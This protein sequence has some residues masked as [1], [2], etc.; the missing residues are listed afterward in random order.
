M[1][2]YFSI[3]FL[4]VFLITKSYQIENFIKLNIPYLVIFMMMT[5]S[6]LK[7]M[8]FYDNPLK[9][10]M[11]EKKTKGMMPMIMVTSIMILDVLFF[12]KLQDLDKTVEFLS[13]F[14]YI[15]MLFY[16]LKAF[17]YFKKSN[18]KIMYQYILIL[19][20]CLL[21]F[22]LVSHTPILI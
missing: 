5:Y 15:I 8:P 20:I 12:T 13:V 2:I 17:S 16:T 1:K 7:Y 4:L 19:M 11:I 9:S 21:M 14:I 10:T 3:N 18:M 22:V 6:I